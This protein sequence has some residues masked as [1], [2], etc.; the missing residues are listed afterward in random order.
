MVAV[1]QIIETDVARRILPDQAGLAVSYVDAVLLDAPTAYYRL[2]EAVGANT[3]LDASGNGRN[4]TYAGSPRSTLG[5]SGALVS[6]PAATAMQIT[7]NGAADVAFGAWQNQMT[8][9]TV[10]AWMKA[11]SGGGVIAARNDDGGRPWFLSADGPN[12]LYFQWV[13]AGLS[14]FFVRTSNAAAIFDG[15]WHH[16]VA[17]YATGV[18]AKL[19]VD[20]VVQTLNGSGSA[21]TTAIGTSLSTGIRIGRRGNGAPVP[22]TGAQIDEVAVYDTALTATRINAHYQAGIYSGPITVSIGQAGD[23]STAR[24]MTVLLGALSVPVGQAEEASTAQPVAPTFGPLEVPVGLD[25]ETDS[26]FTISPFTGG[27]PI[28]VGP[29]EETDAAQAITFLLSPLSVPLAG[30]TE[31]DITNA[32]TVL[33]GTLA[34]PIGQAQSIDEAEPVQVEIGPT[35]GAR[36]LYASVVTRSHATADLGIAGVEQGPTDTSDLA[37]SRTRLGSAEDATTYPARPLP[38][39]L[40][41]GARRIAAQRL[42]APTLVNGRPT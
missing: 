15:N 6:E 36:A 30:V 24:P 23:I 14:G 3:M 21:V 29:A 33:L 7:A 13:N 9:L 40:R 26:A 32:V 37:G 31:A 20:G 34:V 25:V 11:A 39:H 8:G 41:T 18:G 42:P 5:V 1:A 16:V 35:P 19:Y 27:V 2:E 22:F 38:D 4:G 12:G 17:T 10:E 28:L